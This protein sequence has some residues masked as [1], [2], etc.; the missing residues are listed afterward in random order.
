MGGGQGRG[1]CRTRHLPQGL[2][3]QTLAGVK[4]G[5]RGPHS[6]GDRGNGDPGR[7]KRPCAAQSHSRSLPQALAMRDAHLSVQ[8]SKHRAPW[9]PAAS[10]WPKW[11]DVSQVRGRGRGR[12]CWGRGW[13]MPT[14]LD[15]F[16]GAV[17]YLGGCRA[18]T[19]GQDGSVRLKPW[20][21]ASRGEAR[22]RQLERASNCEPKRLSCVQGR[23]A[24][25]GSGAAGDC[26]SGSLHRL[27][28]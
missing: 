27:H 18:E 22:K 15:P 24:R 28:P 16:I 9:P 2:K 26:L 17:L 20:G 10:P 21:A 1:Q 5:L 19:R 3:T 13:P 25:A 4:Q 8:G 23:G 6:R 12:R 7:L 14:S 11:P